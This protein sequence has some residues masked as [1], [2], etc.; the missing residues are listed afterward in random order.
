MNI[1]WSLVVAALPI[2]IGCN[3]SSDRDIPPVAAFPAPPSLGSAIDRAGR[4]A[5]LTAL[6]STFEAA[7]V[8]NAARDAYNGAPQDN[9]ANFK[10]DIRGNLA[11]YDGLDGQC[12]NQILADISLSGPDRYNTLADVLTDDRLYVNSTSNSC[13]QYL[14]VE[15]DVTNLAANEDCGGRTPTEDVIDVSYTALVRSING[16]AITDGVFRDNVVQSIETFPFLATF[17]PPLEPPTL[18]TQIDRAGRSAITA[19]LIST[20]DEITSR[21]N[22]RD[23]YN[24]APQE[25]W[26]QF[27][28]QIGATLAAF[29]GLD[30]SCGNQILA[31]LT[32]TGPAR[33]GTLASV[34]ADDRLYLSSRQGTCSQYLGAELQVTGLAPNTDCGG[35]TPL[36]DTIDTSYTA[37]TNDLSVVVT[38]GVAADNVVSSPTNFPFLVP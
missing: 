29:D 15:L 36:Y 35:R 31:D 34:L 33:Y 30:G 22:D 1:R 7:P 6:V 14:G 21:D 23:I 3:N 12:G 28:T 17:V 2:L 32:E 13:A 11:L 27:S 24:R 20:F 26:A 5:I 9:W 10:D 38:D 4:P 8:R 16:L 18:G 37:L 25:D 19:A